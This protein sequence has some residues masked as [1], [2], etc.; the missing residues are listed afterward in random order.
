[1]SKMLADKI[2]ARIFFNPTDSRFDESV[3]QFQGCPTIAISQKGRIFVGWYSG[4]IC[5]PHMENYNLLVY[6][7]DDGKSWSKPVVVIESSKEDFIH[8]LDIQL[9]TDKDGKL[10]VFWVQNNTDIAP[11]ELPEY[12]YGQPGV[13]K[14][15]Y[16]FEDFVHA[17]WEMVCEDPDADE[18]VFAKPRCWSK[19]F[20]RCKPN[21]LKNGD[22]LFFNY[23]QT[24]KRYGY[25]I[26]S[27]NGKTFEYCYGPEK[28][29]TY[30]DECM[31][32]QKDDGSVRTFA[33]CCFGR[34]AEFTSFDNGRSWTEAKLSDIVASDT[35]FYVAKTPSGKVLLVKNDHEKQR[36]HMTALLS[37]DDGESWENSMLID[38]RNDISYPDADFYGGKIYLVYDRERSGKNSAK[39]I[40]FT[41]FKEEDI[42]KGV[43]PTPV[44]II[45]KP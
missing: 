27:D 17:E 20:L 21:Y 39:E 15:G 7:D 29:G 8:A 41:S 5:E 38:E 9:W 26:S 34:I 37:C 44:Q 10:H 30:F 31:A 43:L 2:P 23:G 14:D 33:R 24:E 3:R 36:S 35:R 40:L 28:I 11:K 45:S 18:L 4:G 32:Y 13:I 16:L 6:S 12:E 25:S 1:M 19:G 42:E 22:I